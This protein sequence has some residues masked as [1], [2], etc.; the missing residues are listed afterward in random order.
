MLLKEALQVKRNIVLL[1]L[2]LFS[3]VLVI[4]QE[5][6]RSPE[7]GNAYN[8]GNNFAK[9]RKYD[10]AINAYK[11][12]I[13]HDSNFPNAHANLGICYKKIG[14]YELAK[15]AYKK[16]IELN[17]KFE[18]VYVAL[19][20][21]YKDQLKEYE[22]AI[23]T[24]NAVITSIN[25]KNY[26]AF[27]G[28]GDVYLKRK[29]FKKGIDNLKKAVEISPK[30]AKAHEKLGDC[31]FEERLFNDAEKSFLNA[32]KNYKDRTDKGESNYKLGNVYLEMRKFKDAESAFSKAA[33]SCK[34][35][36]YKGGANF[37]LGEVYKKLGQ[38]KKAISYYEKAAKSRSWKA[39]SDYQIDILKN[40]DKYSN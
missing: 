21:L 18:N 5:T 3:S 15:N 34:K 7:A 10:Q 29:N 11:E 4:A 9:Q 12:A 22:S 26:K 17:P 19:G 30:L 40:P 39:N 24:Y 28:L 27:Y 14:K 23:N 25:A 1:L 13:K 38:T 36:F 8:N 33:S 37:G 6:K 16:A 35:D 20:N 2:F 31:Q 32:I